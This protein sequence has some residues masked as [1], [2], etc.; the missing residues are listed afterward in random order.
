MEFGIVILCAVLVFAAY[1]AG[2]VGYAIEN[3]KNKKSDYEKMNESI[4]NVI[5][6][7]DKQTR[8]LL[9]KTLKDIGCQPEIDDNNSI[10]FNYQGEKFVINA[11]N[12]SY[13][14]WIYDFAWMGIEISDANADFLKQAI[15]KANGNSAITNL[16][17]IDEE[18]GFIVAHCQMAPYF[19]NNIPNR[20]EYLK[21]ILDAFFF[22]HQRVR[23]EFM[24]LTKK[25]E[26]KE[27][28]EIK[29]FHNN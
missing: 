12:D 5:N 22:A 14:I 3:D 15:N 21:S 19:T 9:I 7:E 2:R 29:G 23:D 16:Y 26:P 13:L 18:K 27:R 1:I 6:E 11:S 17:T 28:V 10:F 20:K 8:S 24:N 25:Q 4:D